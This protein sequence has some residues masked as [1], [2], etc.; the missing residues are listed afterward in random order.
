MINKIIKGIM[1]LIGIT[2]GIGTYFSVV[3]AF[4]NLLPASQISI[5]LGSMVSGLI[6]GFIFFLIAPWLIEEGKNI[7]N[8]VETELSKVP[9]I[10]I[11]IGSLGL[12]IGLFI[13]YLVSNLLLQIPV[14]ILGTVLS[15]LVYILMAYIGIKISVRY[16]E[17]LFNITSI[18]KIPNTKDKS[19][20]KKE[21]KDKPKL[22][23]TSVIIDGR[24]ADIAKTGFVEGKIVIPEFVLKE[25]QHIADSSDDLKRVRGRRGLDILNKIQKE[26]DIEVE[27]TDKDIEEVKEV[28]IKLLKLAQIMGGKVVTND[29]NLNKVAQFQGV[30]VLNINELANAVKPVVIPGEE[31]IV[32]VIKEGKESGQGVAYLDDGTMIVVDGGR[33]YI[34][35]TIDVLVTSVLQT[36]AGRMIFGKPKTAAEKSS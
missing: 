9:P 34:G 13:A 6:M 35:E 1:S 3:G 8:F 26:L 10:E 18:I 24:I 33:K 29:F 20:S 25:L 30:E 2:I 11:L 23:D 4:P 7:A 17:D 28:D 5:I 36:A 31:M 12:I 14:P 27:I 16:K 32:Q 21:V 15:V 19:N 22:L